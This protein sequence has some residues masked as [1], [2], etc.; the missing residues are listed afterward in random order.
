MARYIRGI[1]GLLVGV[2][3]LAGCTAGPPGD[4][5]RDAPADDGASQAAS[6]ER[7]VVPDG[8][9]APQSTDVPE[10]GAD[11]R[12][13]RAQN[14]AQA[15]TFVALRSGAGAVPE[16]IAQGQLELSNGCIVFRQV[17][18]DAALAILPS[19]SRLIDGK[20]LSI[21]GRTVLL[22][23]RLSVNGGPIPSGS[24]KD[25]G[26][27]APVPSQCPAAMFVIGGLQ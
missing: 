20:S 2:A 3:C 4:T 1:Q 6:T 5:G 22:G 25:Y 17:G 16:A 24:G 9:S 18:A 8:T 21:G 15:G 12:P 27:V 23:T 13:D 10:H 26:L 7:N 19:G 14:T 11:N